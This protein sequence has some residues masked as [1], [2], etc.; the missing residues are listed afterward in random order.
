MP[1]TLYM[2]QWPRFSISLKELKTGFTRNKKLYYHQFVS[3]IFS[4]K[5]TLNGRLCD[6][7][8]GPY[9]I[10]VCQLSEAKLCQ[11]KVQER[12]WKVKGFF[13]F[14]LQSQVS[15]CRQ[16]SI[17][18][19]AFAVPSSYNT[20][21]FCHTVRLLQHLAAVMET[22]ASSEWP[23]PHPNSRSFVATVSVSTV[24]SRGFLLSYEIWISVLGK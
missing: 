16:A 22:G 23:I 7:G 10:S 5:S 9:N 17:A 11:W 13:F 20:T 18:H 8:D 3:Y 12:Y 1:V 19:A 6:P 2:Q 24:Q 15:S 14:F 21:S 4:S